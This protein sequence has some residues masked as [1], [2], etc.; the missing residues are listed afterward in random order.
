MI[1]TD[2]II[3]LIE[4]LRASVAVVDHMKYF[5]TCE[6]VLH[7]SNEQA[8]TSATVADFILQNKLALSSSPPGCEPKKEKCANLAHAHIELLTSC[9]TWREK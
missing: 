8:F 3:T 1:Q 5:W 7:C 4:R 2:V 9:E 6:F